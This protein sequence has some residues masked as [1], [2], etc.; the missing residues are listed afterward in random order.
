[1]TQKDRHKQH[2]A[3]DTDCVLFPM[4]PVSIFTVLCPMLPVF[5]CLCLVPKV[6]RVHLSVC[7]AQCYL[8][9]SFCVLCSMLPVCNLLCLV[10]NVTGNIG[11]KTVI[12]FYLSVFCA[13][14]YPVYL[15]VSCAQ[16]Y[17]CLSFFVLCPTLLVSIFLCLEHNVTRF[18]LS[19]S[20]AQCYSCLS[21]FVL[22]KTHKD[23]HG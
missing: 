14:C 3:Q 19:V 22:N 9:L 18:Y 8:C 5:I 21:F 6:T 11:H 2:W 23:R 13:Q 4:L 1:M 10:P 12:H 16:C 17:S 15:S 20:C 7:C